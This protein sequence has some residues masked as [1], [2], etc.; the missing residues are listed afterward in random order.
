MMKRILLSGVAALSLAGAASAGGYVSGN[1]ADLDGSDAWSLNGRAILGGHVMLDAGYTSLDSG[2]DVFN[3]GAHVF[4]TGTDWLLGGYAGGASLNSAGASLSD[5]V[6]AAEGQYHTGRLTLAATVSY[7]ELDTPAFD[8]FDQWNVNGALRYFVTD[9][10]S[11]EANGA[12][13]ETTFTLGGFSTSFSGSYFGL[14]AEYQFDTHPVSIFAAYRHTDLGN[15]GSNID[16]WGIGL[17]WNFGA[18]TL[19]ARDRAGE[20]LRRPE[21][22]IEVLQGGGS[23]D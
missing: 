3:V 5:W 8:G 17:R 6:V 12:W 23:I 14:G 10:F 19:I 15:G 22:A 13:L 7:S 20:R 2:G 21:G 1:Y 4:W 18:G 16:T 9:N 11:L